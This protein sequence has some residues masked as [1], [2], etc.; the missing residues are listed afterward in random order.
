MACPTSSGL[1]ALAERAQPTRALADASMGISAV[2][3]VS[4]NPGATALMVM[5]LL[6]ELFARGLRTIADDARLRLAE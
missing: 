2:R 6:G 5:P 3:R 1:A 4:M